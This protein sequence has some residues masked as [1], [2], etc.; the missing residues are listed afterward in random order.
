MS[1]FS[2]DFEKEKENISLQSLKKI[3]EGVNRYNI[4]NIGLDLLKIRSFIR[5]I[6][7]LR[8]Y[9]IINRFSKQNN[10]TNKVLSTQI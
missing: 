6:D 8:S 7:L 2:Q 1:V 5:E 10:K 4:I 3:T 9:Q